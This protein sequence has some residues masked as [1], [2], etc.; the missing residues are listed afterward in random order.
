MSYDSN[1]IVYHSLLFPDRPFLFA[2]SHGCAAKV[3]AALPE[4]TF[5]ELMTYRNEDF[6]VGSPENGD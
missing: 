3:G 5:A 6:R 1:P 4:V 2:R